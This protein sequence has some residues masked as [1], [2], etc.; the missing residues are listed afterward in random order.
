MATTNKYRINQLQEDGSLLTLHPETDAS[1]VKIN[2][3]TAGINATNVQDAVKEINDSIKA[4]TGGGV[5][6]GVKGSAE[7]EYRLGNVNIT[8][9]NIG[10]GNVDNT[11]DANKPISTATQTALNLKEDK[12][13]L[14]ALAYKDSVSKTDVGLG[15]LTNE[16]Q[17]PLSQKGVAG[18]V[19]TLDS[20]GLIPTS[21]LPSYVDDVVEYESKS[22]FPTVGES[23]IIYVDRTTNIVYRWGGSAY[24][25]ISSSLALGET[26]STAYAGD[27]GKANASAIATLQTTVGGLS[28]TVPN[29]TSRIESAENSIVQH[30]KDITANTNEITKIK[31]GTTA[32]G[33][34]S[35]LNGQE[36][37]YYLNYNNLTNK[38][39]VPTVPDLEVIT[40]GSG[41]FVKDVAV[42]E[43]T[44]TKTLGSIAVSDLPPSGVTAGTYC[45]VAVNAQGLVTAGGNI[46]E[47]GVSGQTT[48]S[49][50]LVAGG[51]F[52]QLVE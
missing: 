45:A 6:T 37:S 26:S 16:A 29:N 38:P 24:V 8:K 15:N 52:Y 40:S 11:S 27:K 7:T 42:S 25:E 3:T 43:H 36:A 19:A 44:I 22:K 10:L 31:N 18:G 1:V 9:A 28:T 48:P 5:V 23:G 39:D 13:K 35:K 50:R 20:S 17:I 12:S 51:I 47:V 30:G 34:A 46:I 2:N 32:V 4:I 21:Q 14:K 41:S 33:N 49:N